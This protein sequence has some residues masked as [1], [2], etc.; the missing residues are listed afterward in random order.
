KFKEGTPDPNATIRQLL[1][2]TSGAS[3]NLAFAYRPDRL[4]ALTAAVRACT[5]DSYRET[6]ANLFERNAMM[7]SVPGP[8]VV[9]LVPPAEGIP[10]ASAVERYTKV[11]ENLAT[12][13]SVD[14]RGRAAPSQYTTT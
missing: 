8:D 5:G 12:P 10:T 1:T 11:L 2:H 3:D 6:L 14:K 13:Y 4:A 7:D 9:R